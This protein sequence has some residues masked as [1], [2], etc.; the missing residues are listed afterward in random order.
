MNSCLRLGTSEFGHFDSNLSF[1][2]SLMDRCLGFYRLFGLLG[3]SMHIGHSV[4]RNYSYPT[5]VGRMVKINDRVY[6]KKSCS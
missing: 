4:S 2:L 1:V 6:G 3:R 5:S